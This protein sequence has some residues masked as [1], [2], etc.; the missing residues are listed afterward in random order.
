MYLEA[1]DRFQEYLDK[2][3]ISDDYYQ[4]QWYLADTLYAAGEYQRAIE[5][6]SDHAAGEDKHHFGAWA[7][8]TPQVHRQ[9]QQQY[10]RAQPWHLLGGADNRGEPANLER[11][12]IDQDIHLTWLPA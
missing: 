9:H 10:D 2:F 8:R 11:G 7:K 5:Q 1:A 3:P 12:K 6:Q 4:Q